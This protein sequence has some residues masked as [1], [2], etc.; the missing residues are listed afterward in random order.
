MPETLNYTQ[1]EELI[2]VDA[3]GEL[4]VADFHNFAQY[5]SEITQSY[6]VKGI[7]I[8][9]RKVELLPEFVNVFNMG[10]QAGQKLKKLKIAFVYSPHLEEKYN[11]FSNSGNARG[12]NI[13]LFLKRD[14]ALEWLKMT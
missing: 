12:A 6:N 1:E 5:L 13:Q 3:Y 4:T 11:L 2:I 10:S 8:D 9:H 14:K 7:L